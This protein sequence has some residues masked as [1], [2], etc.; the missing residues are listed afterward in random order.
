MSPSPVAGP[1]TTNRSSSDKNSSHH[2]PGRPLTTPSDNFAFL[3]GFAGFHGPHFFGPTAAWIDRRKA[4][5]RTSQTEL[6]SLENSVKQVTSLRFVFFHP[7]LVLFF[8][9]CLWWW[10][11]PLPIYVEEDVVP[12]VDTDICPSWFLAR[13]AQNLLLLGGFFGFFFAALYLPPLRLRL[14][15]RKYVPESW[16]TIGNL[17]HDGWYFGIGVFVYTVLEAGMVR[18][19]R[20][21]V[22][23]YWY[24]GRAADAGGSRAGADAPEEFWSSL[25]IVNEN[26]NVPGQHRSGNPPSSST[27][28]RSA[29]VLLTAL[30]LLL[31]PLYREFHFYFAHRVLHI[32]CIYRFVHALHH[33]NADPQ[34]F[35]G[36]AMHPVEH[37]WYFS[38]AL[39]P[40][41]LPGIFSWFPPLHPIV[42]L[43]SLLHAALAAC[44]GHSGFEDHWQ[45]DQYHYLH[46]AKFECNYG[47]PFTGWID[48]RCGTFRGRLG[49]AGSGGVE[50]AEDKPGC[51]ADSTKRAEPLLPKKLEW[52]PQGYLGL[53]T[54]W[55][56]AYSLFCAA[57]FLVVSA[58]LRCLDAIP[59]LFADTTVQYSA[60]Q[61]LFGNFFFF[62]R[63]DLNLSPHQL[64]L[65]FAF[66]PIVAAWL[67]WFC[68]RDPFSWRWP[69]ESEAWV[70]CFGAFCALNFFTVLLPLYAWV[71]MLAAA[72]MVVVSQ[73][74][75]N[76]LDQRY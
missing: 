36:L 49:A 19:W 52:S 75:N 6:L 44:S 72:Q 24:F 71:R 63:E 16:P 58:E 3:R 22:L 45:A 39:L 8:I 68:S 34:P 32:R 74:P 54:G 20:G 43:W 30:S 35:S 15:S 11:N 73:Y 60:K 26:E 27:V 10:A 31:T 1:C 67:F 37:L 13:L 66:S 29:L 14:A 50:C 55:Q 40:A 23:P 57:V 2:D 41:L 61:N 62:P 18:L 46:H 48:Q 38:C 28:S 69:F 76:A 59:Q 21:G 7:N 12:A 17:I 51:R 9:L 5:G 25:V 64:G 65:L 70:G 42:F 53:Q 33:R 47:S 4:P 56:L